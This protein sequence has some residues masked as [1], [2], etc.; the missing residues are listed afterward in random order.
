MAWLTG[1]CGSSTRLSVTR[2][3]QHIPT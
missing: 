1:G 3:N 2:L